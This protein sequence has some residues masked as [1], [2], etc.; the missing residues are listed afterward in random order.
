MRQPVR[1]SVHWSK[2]F[3][4]HLRTVHFALLVVSAGLILLLVSSREYNAVSA[5][6]QVEQII[7]LKRQ[8]SEEWIKKYGAVSYE[9]YAPP[10]EEFA[11]DA[12]LGAITNTGTNPYTKFYPPLCNFGV[13][14]LELSPNKSFVLDCN[15]PIEH[16][17]I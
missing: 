8:W 2:D 5:L 13:G 14:T 12:Q 9:H 11:I 17:I 1:G 16:C 3:V 15:P 6:V 7:D 10:K 4:E